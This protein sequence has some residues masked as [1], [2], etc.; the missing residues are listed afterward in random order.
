[1]IGNLKNA[2]NLHL[3]VPLMFGACFGLWLVGA[4]NKTARGD[5]TIVLEN[6][7]VR[8]VLE[9]DNEVWR[10]SSLARADGSDEVALESDEFRILLMGGTKLS[11]DD[12][13]S[14]D[15]PVIR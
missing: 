1:M 8:R 10:T 6:P 12:Y 11:L 2:A 13:R 7:L 15:D 9:R 3:L 5:A 14:E 4:S